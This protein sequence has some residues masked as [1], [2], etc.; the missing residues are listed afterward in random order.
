MILAKNV[1]CKYQN[2]DKVL[3]V[4]DNVSFEIKDGEF[5][6]ITG[7]SGSGKTTLLKILSGIQKPN[8]GEVYWD[9]VNLYQL[10]NRFQSKLRIKESGF[11][12]QDFML[13]DELNVY[14]NIKLQQVL[15][16]K[17]DKSM[18]NEIINILNIQHLIKKYPQTLSGGQK[19]L[20]AI[21]R[22]LV[23]NPS[24]LFCDEPTG[25]LD[26]IATKEIMDLLKKLN[27]ELGV[28]IILVTHEQENL[29]YASRII[30][31]HNGMLECD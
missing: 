4:L 14:D 13:I 3:T 8:S 9:D 11:I 6:I 27:Q 23:N 29:S 26:Y 1:T 18:I 17:K 12:Y 25:S 24:I 2:G 31:Y 10:S 22:A 15:N 19:Q 30:K 16:N 21:G 28:T 5:V 20:V 7:A